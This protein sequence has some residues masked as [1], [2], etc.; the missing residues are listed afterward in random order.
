MTQHL[1]VY[2]TLAPGKE[3][4]HWL[5]NI[6]GSWQQAFIKGKYSHN[7]WGKTFGYPAVI[8]DT[9]T[10]HSTDN[11]ANNVAGLLFTSNTLAEH[12]PALDNFEGECYQRV[13]TTVTLSNE[14]ATN[15]DNNN[16]SN[17]NSVTVQAFIYVLN[18]R[19]INQ[20]SANLA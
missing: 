13:L 18:P 7:G 1:F 10:A 16:N 20:V 6:G 12:W 4:E 19:L 3:N 11:S 17:S 2:G 5:K 14:T 15:N 8:L 9:L